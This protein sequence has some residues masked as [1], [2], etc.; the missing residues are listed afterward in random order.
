[1][2]TREAVEAH[3]SVAQDGFCG[4][5]AEVDGAM[6]TRVDRWDRPGG[7]GGE[8]RILTGRVVER[9]AVN[10]SAVWGETPGGLRDRMP[11]LG[12]RFYA[13]GLSIIVHPHNPYVPTFHA[14]VRYFETDETAWFGGGA[15]LTP[16]YLHPD[17]AAMFHRVLAD[18]CADHPTS[19]HRSWKAWCDRYFHLPHRGEARGVG[20]IFYDRVGDDLEGMWEFHRALAEGLV[21]LYPPIVERRRSQ[22]F[23]A[24]ERHWQE[25]RRGR[26]VEFNLVWDRGTRFGL[27]SGGRTESILASLPPRARWDDGFEPEPGSPEQVLVEVLRGDPV[28]WATWTN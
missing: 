12:P 13:T 3:L 24:R 18:L 16:H 22:P 15:D 10:V 11:E 17:D 27:E 1:V 21:D 9:A 5:L 20:G 14:N 25:L 2:P 7:G 6:H 23:G 4:A 19:D 28:E 8:T 26:Y